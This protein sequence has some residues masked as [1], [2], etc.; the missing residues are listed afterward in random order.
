MEITQS[1][2]LSAKE[3][4]SLVEKSIMI[5]AYGHGVNVQMLNLGKE[6]LAC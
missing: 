5:V 1:A 3:S 2:T 6:M 4:F